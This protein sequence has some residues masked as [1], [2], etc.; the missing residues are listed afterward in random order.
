MGQHALLMEDYNAAT[1]GQKFA[2]K[3][4]DL[5][6]G[7]L[8][9]QVELLYELADGGPVLELG[10]GTGRL[11]LPLVGRDIDVFGI[12]SSEAMVAQLL[13]KPGADRV[14]V[15]RGDFRQFDL[16]QRFPLVFVA[17]NTI[18][19]LPD[20]EAQLACFATVSRHLLPGGRFLVEAF[21]PDPGRFD[22]GQR[23]GVVRVS[24]D[25]VLLECSRHD[26]VAQ[27]VVTQQVALG[28]T[29][30]RLFPVRTRY[31]WPP[32]LD[33]MARIAGLQLEGRWDG[34]HRQPYTATSFTTV[35]VWRAPF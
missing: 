12:D 21:V 3:Y 11:A 35:S 31:A 34:W 17:F 27:T 14:R 20:Q 10:I 19:A 9:G 22:R 33:L 6:R 5:H 29:G 23:L 18:F 1:Y 26:P 7:P 4:D 24:L 2:D 32:E 16:G 13:A 25:E 30:T 28:A 15:T 8:P